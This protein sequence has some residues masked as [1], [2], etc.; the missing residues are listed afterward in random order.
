MN[1]SKT[2]NDKN[3][4]G[5]LEEI[6]K[7]RGFFWPSFEIYQ[8]CSGFYTYGPLGALLKARIEK[9]FRDFYLRQG[10]LLMDAPILTTI[11]PWVASGHVESFNDMTIECEKCGEAYRA[12]HLVEEK[13]GKATEGLSL[14]EIQELIEKNNIT[15][16][17]CSSKLG[18]VY[19][20]NLMFKTLIGPGK[21]KIEGVL[22][23]ETAQTTYMPFKRLYELGRKKLPLGVIQI[24]RSMR[25]EISPRKVLVRLREFNQVEVQFF[26]H[27][28]QKYQY[29]ETRIF[30]QIKNTSVFVLTKHEQEMGKEASKMKIADLVKGKHVNK[31]IA[32]FLACSIQ[33][34][35]KMGIDGKKLRI[36]QHK[37]NERSFYSAD[38]WDVEFLS[39]KYGRIELVGIADRTDY[40]L[41]RHQKMSKQDMS[42]KYN[43]EKFVPHVIEIA[44]GVDRP[45][46]CILESCIKQ[47]KNRVYFSF[48]PSIAPYQI[49]IF[50]LVRKDGLPEKARQVYS[51]LNNEFLALYDETGSIGRLYYRQDEAGTPFCITIDYDTLKK[52][53]VTIRN[54]DNQKQI[55]V[56]IKDLISTLK[57][58]MNNEVR[59]EKAGRL[60]KG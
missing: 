16:P 37:D 20:Y 48:P 40:D 54:R 3:I 1:A 34:Y 33:L 49:A 59:F 29:P 26:I 12:D 35:V 18:R 11:D 50:P 32:Y 13:T 31:M 25:N 30:N 45:L 5:K 9:L 53:D 28:R 24:G 19:D 39:D 7:R 57:K 47:E 58:I 46:L 44:Y 2:K 41:K 22:R 56:N 60:V 8:G 21:N 38:T 51:M 10:C 43:G 17:K 4:L 42:I 23:P 14:P 36:R 52:E 15:C 6:A 55:R 27:P